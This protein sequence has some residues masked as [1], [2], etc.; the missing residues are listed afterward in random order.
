MSH[1]T[2]EIRFDDLAGAGSPKADITIDEMTK[3]ALNKP[4]KDADSLVRIFVL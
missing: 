4:D 2:V 3:E 1:A